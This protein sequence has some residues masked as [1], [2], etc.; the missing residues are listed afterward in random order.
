MQN[1][2]Q[3]EKKSQYWWKKSGK[4]FV[5]LIFSFL[6][7]ALQS[8][9]FVENIQPF[10]FPNIA[11]VLSVCYAIRQGGTFSL[12][13]C[14]CNGLAMDVLNGGEIGKCTFLF[15]VIGLSCVIIRRL[16][17]CRSF[18]MALLIVVVA[19]QGYELALLLLALLSTNGYPFWYM[20][21]HVALPVTI[22]NAAVTLVLFPVAVWVTRETNKGGKEN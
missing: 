14:A 5:F 15:F 8:A 6:V 18:K 13:F 3:E 16:I 7:L 4:I 20:Y 1:Y 10:A 9:L 19:T 17:F 12:F 22:S 21:L 11:L 2:F